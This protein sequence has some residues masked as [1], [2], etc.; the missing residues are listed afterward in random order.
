MAT[1]SLLTS[2]R[3]QRHADLGLEDQIAALIG[4]AEH[5]GR[6]AV[7]GRDHRDLAEHHP[8]R[9]PRETRKDE[10]GRDR[11][12]GHAEQ[13]LAGDE[14]IG[15]ECRR[16]HLAIADRRHGLNA[17]KERIGEGARPR[18]GDAA[19][20]DQIERRESEIEKDITEDEQREDAR[21]RQGQQ[22]VIDI[23]PPGAARDDA[24]DR[25]E[26]GRLCRAPAPALGAAPRRHRALVSAR[27]A[28]G[29]RLESMPCARL[30][31]DGHG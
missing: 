3:K 14:Q 18:V 1:P 20:L 17:E 10:S 27:H 23:E 8:R 15:V 31:A 30:T 24:L 22:P 9:R 6:H 13:H 26:R 29:S 21:P 16:P 11:E 12:A 4:G 2:S 7:M 28:S 25:A 19:V 5:Q